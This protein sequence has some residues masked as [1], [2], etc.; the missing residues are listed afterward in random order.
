MIRFV[1]GNGF[2]R[3]I[4][5]KNPIVTNGQGEL[6]IEGEEPESPAMKAGSAP[7]PRPCPSKP[8]LSGQC[9]PSILAV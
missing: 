8:K 1:A 7:G 4:A 3:W 2:A 6:P 9:S 5:P